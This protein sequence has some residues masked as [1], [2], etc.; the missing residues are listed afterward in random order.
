MKTF[1]RLGL[2]LLSP[3]LLVVYWRNNLRQVGDLQASYE[4]G[5]E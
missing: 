4:L 2:I 5:Y 3:Y 1:V